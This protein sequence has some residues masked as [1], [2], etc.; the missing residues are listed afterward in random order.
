MRAS[1]ELP[2]ARGALC[3]LL[4]STPT[5]AGEFTADQF[6]WQAGPDQ[7]ALKWDVRARLGDGANRLWLLN[8]GAHA[9]GDQV[10]NRVELL[11]GH[12]LTDRWE[13]VAGVRH[14]DGATPSRT[15]AALGLLA[16]APESF[17][18]EA[19]GYVGDYGHVGLRLKA[20]YDW[21]IGSRLVLTARGEGEV[22]NDDHDR[23]R[24]GSGPIQVAAGLRLKYKIRPA[25]APYAGYEWKR[26]LDDTANQAERAGVDPKRRVWVA[27]VSFSF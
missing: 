14:D 22:W 20:D 8:E 15:Y 13:L 21:L 26:L 3:L 2:L 27:G 18:I 9:S 7:D 17:R 6:E 25:F 12:T 11:W 5:T 16:F 24:V 10:E 1:L 19:T 4:A 23:V